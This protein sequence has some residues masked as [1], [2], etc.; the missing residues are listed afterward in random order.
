M[1]TQ[2]PDIEVGAV[3]LAA[4]LGE[5]MNHVRVPKPLV[6]MGGISL[7]ERTYRTVRLGGVRGT[8]VVVVGHR[9]D[10]IA[11]FARDRY[12][13]VKIVEN[14]R[15]RHGNGTSVLAALPH[16]PERFVVAMADHVHTPASVGALL[17]CRGD[18]VAAVDTQPAYAD[19]EEATHVRLRCGAV[20][21]IGKGLEPYD[22][23][24]TGLFVCSGPALQ[25]LALGPQDE[26]TWNAFKRLWLES[27]R[28]IEA[29]D[30]RGAPW[31]DVDCSPDLRR[32]LDVV[33]RSVGSG[34][35]GFVSRHLNRKLSTPITRLMLTTPV[36]PDQVSAIAF[37]TAVGGA[38]AMLGN[39]WRLGAALVQLSSI[40]DGCDGELARAR[41]E[42]SPRGA[43]FDATL[44]RLADG[45][46]IA[47]MATG[48]G[49]KRAHWAGYLAL[50][51]ALLVPYTRA[52]MEA[53]FGEM[54]RKLT[55]FG[56]T[57]DVRLAA[58][59]LGALVGRPLPTLVAVAVSS[60]IEVVRRLGT[61][62]YSGK[63]ED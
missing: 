15:Y 19:R 10:E 2:R 55:R 8:I 9:G 33:I 44:D 36:N 39:R 20:V 49:S 59:A 63:Q 23:L 3:I 54:P 21:A 12:L 4:G 45:L 27:D 18:F 29:C 38:A 37:L 56:V 51:G 61:R 28:M 14:P 43:V 62:P 41:L 24:D 50:T 17:A 1:T 53:E 60:N 46:V 22:A 5:R 30:I 35:E 58:L 40:L 6:R 26:L 47:G 25:Q 31:I 57:R 16:L 34:S 7:L 13:D 48:A 32:A 42:S 52:K 11:R